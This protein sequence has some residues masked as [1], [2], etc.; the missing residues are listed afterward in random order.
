MPCGRTAHCSRTSVDGILSG[1]LGG[2]MRIYV[3]NSNRQQVGYADFG[4]TDLAFIEAVARASQIGAPLPSLDV[5]QWDVDVYNSRGRQVGT[6]RPEKNYSRMYNAEVTDCSSSS[7]GSRTVG[8]V[9]VS[10]DTVSLWRYATTQPLPHG[11]Y[12]GVLRFNSDL[13]GTVNQD[14]VSF[15]ER[16]RAIGTVRIEPSPHLVDRFFAGGK[17][18]YISQ[19]CAFRPSAY[20]GGAALLLLL[21]ELGG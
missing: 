21:P 8:M 17:P 7:M 6:I 20:A 12:V 13:E 5:L 9:Q 14:P 2:N 10:M 3:S 4:A 15:H 1:V 19:I 11:R 18:Y 16:N